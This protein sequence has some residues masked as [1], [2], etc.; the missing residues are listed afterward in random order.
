MKVR[1]HEY[2]KMEF[3]LLINTFSFIESGEETATTKDKQ[4]LMYNWD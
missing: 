1:D 4:A 3:E 2:Q